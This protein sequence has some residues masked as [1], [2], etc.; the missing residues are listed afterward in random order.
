MGYILSG[1]IGGTKTRLQIS[2][3]G[4]GDPVLQMSFLSNRYSSLAAIIDEFLRQ[5]NITGIAAAC[6]A[7]AGPVLGRQVG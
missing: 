5:A 6:F 2:A 1:D 7:L 3:I 4:Q